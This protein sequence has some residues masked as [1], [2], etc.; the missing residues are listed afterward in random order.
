MYIFFT[1]NVKIFLLAIK[2]EYIE[3]F[4]RVVYALLGLNIEPDPEHA[5]LL[6]I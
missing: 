6:R 3:N 2:Q 5:E 1:K 4:R